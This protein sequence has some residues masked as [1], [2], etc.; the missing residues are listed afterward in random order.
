MHHLGDVQS[1]GGWF[2]D[3]QDVT[4]EEP[5]PALPIMRRILGA[6][7]TNRATLAQKS[8]KKARGTLGKRAIFSGNGR[9]LGL[10]SKGTRP[11]FPTFAPANHPG[12]A[13]R[14]LTNGKWRPLQADFGSGTGC[15]GVGWG[16]L[17]WVDSYPQFCGKWA[18]PVR[19]GVDGV[20]GVVLFH[21]SDPRASCGPCAQARGRCSQPRF[22]LA[23]TRTPPP[24]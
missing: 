6:T 1:R 23:P 11:Y 20:G 21:F 2:I 7:K 19:F 15:F 9:E 10:F 8:W 3:L 13:Q 14:A 12:S 5:Q 24:G 16:G 18:K 4:E 17:G 22:R